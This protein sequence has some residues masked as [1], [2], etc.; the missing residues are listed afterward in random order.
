MQRNRKNGNIQ[1]TYNKETETKRKF[2]SPAASKAVI[3]G[4]GLGILGLIKP[5]NYIKC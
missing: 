3:A 5:S 4:M 1:L 2:I